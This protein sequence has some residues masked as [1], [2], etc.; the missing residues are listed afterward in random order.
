MK[1]FH[2]RYQNKDINWS[3]SLQFILYCNTT[4]SGLNFIHEFRLLRF[5]ILF[6]VGRRDLQKVWPRDNL[7]C[8]NCF[9]LLVISSRIVFQIYLWLLYEHL[10][11]HCKETPWRFSSKIRAVIFQ[12]IRPIFN[13]CFW[14]RPPMIKT[15]IQRNWLIACFRSMAMVSRKCWVKNALKHAN[16]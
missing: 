3:F 15:A 1:R 9:H 11:V 16:K 8:T 6:P 12:G 5:L 14:W 4:N 13:I 10:C 2:I 7:S